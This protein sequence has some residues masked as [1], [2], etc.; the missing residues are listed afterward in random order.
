MISYDITRYHM[1]SYDIIRCHMIS[2][3]QLLKS[4]SQNC[5][6]GASFK[7]ELLLRS[8]LLRRNYFEGAELGTR[9]YEHVK[10]TK[11]VIFVTLPVVG[12]FKS[13]PTTCSNMLK[14]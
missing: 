9:A 2:Y 1:I 6:V 5:S 14:L 10:S 4:S 7:E 13:R 11:Y 12:S 8:L 3:T